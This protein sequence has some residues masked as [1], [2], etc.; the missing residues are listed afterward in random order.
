MVFER[1]CGFPKGSRR[2]PPSWF[3]VTAH[4]ASEVGSSGSDKT[5]P[6][7]APV[8]RT[9]SQACLCTLH[10][11]RHFSEIF[12]LCCFQR[13]LKLSAAQSSKLRSVL[14]RYSR[15]DLANSKVQM[16]KKE[17]PVQARAEK[18]PTREAIPMETGLMSQQDVRPT[19]R[20]CSWRPGSCLCPLTQPL[21]SCV[22]SR[23]CTILTFLHFF[24]LAALLL[25]VALS[26]RGGFVR[27]A[28]GTAQRS[29]RLGAATMHF[30]VHLRPGVYISGVT[31]A[32]GLMWDLFASHLPMNARAVRA[33]FAAAIG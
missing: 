22:W 12:F 3:C 7:T 27:A 19:L 10:R 18:N 21:L 8:M 6:R 17:K 13:L 9:R 32:D 5:H 24:L 30:T 33:R 16:L 4:L 26:P 31:G 20:M 2:G 1:A 14:L 29:R 25:S 23:C 11:E 15:N 28:A